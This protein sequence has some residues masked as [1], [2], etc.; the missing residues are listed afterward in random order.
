MNGKVSLVGAGP[1]DPRL[2]TLGALEALK[3][4]DLV[5]YDTLANPDHLRHARTNAKKICVGRD[6]RHRKISQG[7]INR[8]I[9]GAARKG[10]SVVR[11]KGGDPYLF[12]RGGEEALFLRKHR[13]PFEVVPGVTS[14]TACAAYAGI[15]LTHREHNASVTFLTGHRAN[16]ERL[17]T[18]PWKTIAALGGTLVIYMG[19][20]NLAK[21]AMRLIRAGRPQTTR[22]CVVE[23]GTLPRQKSCDGTLSDISQKVK[24]AKLKAPCLIIV[25]GVVSLR[26]KLNWYEQLPFF[27]KKIVITRTRDK[28]AVLAGKL[29]RLGAQVFE[30]PVIEIKRPSGWE[31]MDKAIRGLERFDWVVFTSTYGVDFFFERLRHHKKDARALKGVKIACVGPGTEEA[32]SRRGVTSE[33]VPEHFETTAIAVEFKKKF[34]HLSGKN[35][36]LLRADIAPEALDLALRRLGAQITRIHAYRTRLPGKIPLETKLLLI[37]GKMDWVTFT[38]ASTIDHFVKILGVGPVKKLAK[39]TNFASIGPVTSAALRRY[40]FKPQVQA[41]VYTVEGLV[42]AMERACIRSRA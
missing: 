28:G 37:K 16:D 32:L 36:L 42:K 21:I 29:E 22:V 7:K 19:F 11:L 23:W 13:I 3:E 14:A 2:L 1:G 8:L 15:P 12:G 9:I 27:G 39:R 30:F 18:I 35:I 10:Q 25:G 34:G 4:A 40:G 41:K 38:S 24:H 31:A 5:I 17:D 26:K 6:F 20:Y 33:L